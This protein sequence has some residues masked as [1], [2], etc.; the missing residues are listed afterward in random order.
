M[1]YYKPEV[2]ECSVGGNSRRTLQASSANMPPAELTDCPTNCAHL[3]SSQVS[4]QCNFMS[5]C[6]S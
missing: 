5:M 3:P 2:K 6:V 1:H 4:V